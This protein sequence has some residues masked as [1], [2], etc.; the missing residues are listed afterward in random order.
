MQNTGGQAEDLCERKEKQ[1]S[2][3]LA[4]E[5]EEIEEMDLFFLFCFCFFC[6]VCFSLREEICC[7]LSPSMLLL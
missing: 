1:I 2:V 6:V 7:P 5:T 3:A 4:I